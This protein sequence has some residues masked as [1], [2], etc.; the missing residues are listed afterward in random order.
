LIKQDK[1]AIL[2]RTDDYTPESNRERASPCAAFLLIIRMKMFVAVPAAIPKVEEVLEGTIFAL[3]E[4]FFGQSGFSR[5]ET[6]GQ[7][8]FIRCDYPRQYQWQL[9]TMT[10]RLL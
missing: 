2:D 6:A 7:A 5:V 8:A 9:S 4:E 3:K 1:E 10:S